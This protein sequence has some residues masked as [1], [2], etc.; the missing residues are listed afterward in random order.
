MKVINT[1]L[2]LGTAHSRLRLSAGAVFRGSLLCQML[3]NS[4]V[5]GLQGDLEK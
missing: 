4:L 2:G 5:A 3:V 1:W